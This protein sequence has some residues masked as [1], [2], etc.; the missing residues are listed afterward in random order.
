MRPRNSRRASPRAAAA[1]EGSRAPDV[2]IVAHRG[3][4]GSAPENTLAALRRALELGARWAE[5]D[6]QRTADGVLVLVHDDSW[7]RTAGLDRPICDTPWDV[8][9]QLDAGLWFDA[10][11]AGEPPPRL[12]DT[13]ELAAR[14]LCLDLE[15]KSPERHPGLGEQV[16]DAVRRAGVAARVLLT[17]F[18]TA[19]VERLADQAPDV[20]CGYLSTHLE[21][22]EHPRVRSLAVHAAALEA[23]PEAARRATAKYEVLAWTVDDLPCAVRLADLGVRAIV[24]NHPERFLGRL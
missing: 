12:E 17:S 15:I 11:F 5:V 21:P 9:R 24:T 3:A 13:L 8:V 4:S 19:L 6:V 7:Q 10:R 18:D 2:R 14:G 16:V 1:N 20:A 22:G 23:E